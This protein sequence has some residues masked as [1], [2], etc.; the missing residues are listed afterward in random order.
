MGRIAWPGWCAVC[1]RIR[2]WQ[3]RWTM[4]KEAT[5]H[6]PSV[7]RRRNFAGEDC[8]QFESDEHGKPIYPIR[9]AC[10][11]KDTLG[12]AVA[13]IGLAVSGHEM[14]AAARDNRSHLSSR[15]D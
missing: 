8:A 6:F 11:R 13:C 15:I 9:A 5:L 1:N 14:G 3:S 2:R 7:K 10:P 12:R 4:R